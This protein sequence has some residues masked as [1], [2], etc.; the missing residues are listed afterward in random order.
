VTIWFYRPA[1]SAFPQDIPTI[2]EVGGLTRKL[3][4]LAPGEFFG[5]NVQPGPHTFSYTRAPARGQSL[6]LVVKAGQ[7]VYVEVQFRE[8][9]PVSADLGREAVGKCRPV[10][11]LAVLDRSVTV[12]LGSSPVSASASAP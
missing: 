8:L 1:D 6:Y 11:E 2:L 4:R 3:G 12:N 9:K 7:P 5:Y 10:P